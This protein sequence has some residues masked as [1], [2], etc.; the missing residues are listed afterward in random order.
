MGQT[1]HNPGMPEESRQ[2]HICPVDRMD[3]QFLT[4]GFLFTVT[5]KLIE[6]CLMGN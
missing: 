1:S 5:A 3:T 6:I 4:P 2:I